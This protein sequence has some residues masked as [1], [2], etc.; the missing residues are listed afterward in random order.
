MPNFLARQILGVR[1][2]VAKNCLPIIADF[3]KLNYTKPSVD[4]DIDTFIQEKDVKIIQTK[5]WTQ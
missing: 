3:K 2:L 4:D 1:D 5:Q